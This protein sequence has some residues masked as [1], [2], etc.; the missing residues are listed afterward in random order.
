MPEIDGPMSKKPL[1][2]QTTDLARRYGRHPAMRQ[3][4]E[5]F[6]TM[7]VQR[8]IPE[9]FGIIDKAKIRFALLRNHKNFLSRPVI[10][11]DIDIVVHEDFQSQFPKLMKSAGWK[12]AQH[13]YSRQLGYSYLYALP[14][15]E[16]YVR[17]DVY[18]DVTYKL[19]CMSITG[20]HWIPLD[21]KIQSNMWKNIV[22]VNEFWHYELSTV[23]KFIHNLTR[24]VFE[25]KELNDDKITEMASWLHKIDRD[26][27]ED[28]LKTI[29]FKAT[30]MV[31]NLA[32]ESRYRDIRTSLIR[33]SD[34]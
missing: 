22:Q 32:Y 25:K 5:E 15:F 18:V 21:D 11:K 7:A 14:A 6:S 26:L 34:Y 23:D 19:P 13:P 27:L 30:P 12:K 28:Y 4:T 20:E 16:F 3:G 33:F 8:I 17:D 10:K 1:N 24:V 9:I 2:V 29:F 31:M